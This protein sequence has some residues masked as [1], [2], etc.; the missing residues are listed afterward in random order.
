MIGT[1]IISSTITL[2]TW[3]KEKCN[4]KQRN[5]VEALS[6]NYSSQGTNT[7]TVSGVLGEEY[8]L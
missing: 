1:K 3:G 4:M 8:A 5:I 2:H 7:G 6:P